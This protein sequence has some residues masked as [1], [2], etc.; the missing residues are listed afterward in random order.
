MT[1]SEYGEFWRL[2]LPGQY[3]FQVSAWGYESS[4]KV[5][6]TVPQTGVTIKNFTLKHLD[7]WGIKSGKYMYKYFRLSYWF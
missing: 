5:A 1:T 7:L 6:V 4:S 3:Y 2:L